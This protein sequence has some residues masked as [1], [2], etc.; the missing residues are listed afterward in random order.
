LAALIFVKTQ[1]Y[2]PKAFIRINALP[3]GSEMSS[4][5]L[6]L[7]LSSRFLMPGSNLGFRLTSASAPLNCYAV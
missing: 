4:A 2:Y 6:A 7:Q 3:N 5:D 1:V